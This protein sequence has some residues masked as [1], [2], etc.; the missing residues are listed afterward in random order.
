MFGK[1]LLPWL[2]M[3]VGGAS[4][5]APSLSA[6]NGPAVDELIANFPSLDELES[7]LGST[8]NSSLPA[9]S[10]DGSASTTSYLPG[11]QPVGAGQPV[12]LPV[13]LAGRG[14]E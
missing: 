11:G 8:E 9:A 6:Q 5:V 3:L 13:R 4:F 10:P 1:M 2:L 12:F 7:R 14:T